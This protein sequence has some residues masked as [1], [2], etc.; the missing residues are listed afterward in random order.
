M[1]FFLNWRETLWCQSSLLRK[2]STVFTTDPG[3]KVLY[4]FSWLKF[5]LHLYWSE[6]S[7]GLKMKQ[8]ASLE[9]GITINNRNL[10]GNQWKVSIWLA[11]LLLHHIQ[12][13]GL[14][15]SWQFFFFFH[16][17]PQLYS[18]LCYSLNVIISDLLYS[19]ALGIIPVIASTCCR[20][21]KIEQ[22]PSI[23]PVL[24]WALPSSYSPIFAGIPQSLYS[25]S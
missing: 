21:A 1:S 8:G 18:V 25:K 12:K 3:V 9:E 15:S 19:T 16:L 6:Y 23:L 13:I 2:A 14:C 7:K 5:W 10:Q 17:W 24:T 11:V 20:L 4:F 22:T